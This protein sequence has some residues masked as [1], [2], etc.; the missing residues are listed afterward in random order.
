MDAVSAD[1]KGYYES[2]TY[3]GVPG[4]IPTKKQ[5]E[6]YRNELKKAATVGTKTDTTSAVKKDVIAPPK[7]EGTWKEATS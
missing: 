2:G 6:M 5:L 4:G 3:K 7:Q 1:I